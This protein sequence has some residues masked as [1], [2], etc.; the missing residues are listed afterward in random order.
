MGKS[1]FLLRLLEN[2]NLLEH[3]SF[4]KLL[5]AVFQLTEE[6]A[7]RKDVRKLP[8]TDYT[9]LEGDIKRAYVLLVDEWLDYMK[10]LK[11]NYPYLF[12]LA[13]RTNPFDQNVSPIV[14]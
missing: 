1:N 14:E 8:D 13:M 7:Q 11:D 9:H 5:R 4:T 10:Y 3:E 12:S 6:L 2:P